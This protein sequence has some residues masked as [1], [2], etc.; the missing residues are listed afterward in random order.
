[1]PNPFKEPVN[2]AGAAPALGPYQHAIRS[3]DFLY[4]SGQIPI[5]PSTPDAPPPPDIESQTDIV[6]S[7]IRRILAD[8]G[9]GF[10]HVIKT[11][12]F[13]TD[14]GQFSAMN[15]VYARY[16]NPPY[17]ARSTIQVA[18]LPRSSNVEIEVVAR[19]PEIAP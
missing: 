5:S 12:V 18:G 17:P 9:L 4:C 8:Q 3:G 16:F 15:G 19:Y 1:M 14:L 13:M 10:E 7:N 6:L 11:T 2:P